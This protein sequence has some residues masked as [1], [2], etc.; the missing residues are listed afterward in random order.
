MRS[1]P[2]RLRRGVVAVA[3]AG[4]GLFAAC[5]PDP[6]EG[7]DGK[8]IETLPADLLPSEIMGLEVTQE[9]MSASLS[10]QQ[11]SFVDAVG[12]YAM[13]RDEL[14]QAT[15]QVSRFRDN[16]PIDQ[17][18]FRSSVVNQIGGRRVEAYRMGDDTVYRTTGRKQVISLWFHDRSLF[19]LSVR[20]SFEQPRSLLREALEIEA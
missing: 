14:L 10:T 13:R 5:G 1:A 20:D 16:A 6:V 17:A 9:D 8:A 2:L 12:L 15:L 7:T 3:V 18:S 19:V 11:D 4:A